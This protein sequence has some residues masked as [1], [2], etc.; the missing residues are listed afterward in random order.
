MI[1]AQIPRELLTTKGNDVVDLVWGSASHK[2]MLSGFPPLE[3][4]V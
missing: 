2:F 4:Q 1:I 3:W